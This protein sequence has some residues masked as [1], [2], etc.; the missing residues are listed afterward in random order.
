M[1]EQRDTDY[2]GGYSIGKM[3]RA[4]AYIFTQYIKTE[5]IY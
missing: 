3:E 2:T 4:I 5:N 1:I